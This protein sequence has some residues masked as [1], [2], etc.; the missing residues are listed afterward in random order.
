MGAV[1]KTKSI[2]NE[3]FCYRVTQD[4]RGAGDKKCECAE[5]HLT[6]P[7]WCHYDLTDLEVSVGKGNL[8]S[9]PCPQKIMSLEMKACS[10]VA[11]A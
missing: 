2:A 4:R 6:P 8:H 3:P 7:E 1:Y 11:Q 5:N 9:P 10:T